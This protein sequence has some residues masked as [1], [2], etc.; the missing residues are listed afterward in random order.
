MRLKM[1]DLPSRDLQMPVL[2]QSVLRHH[3]ETSRAVTTARGS[4]ETG[5]AGRETFAEI[6]RCQAVV[7]SPSRTS[8]S[9]C[10]MDHSLRTVKLVADNGRHRS[11][12]TPLS[13][14]REMGKITG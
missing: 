12:T 11:D 9:P 1:H 8:A 7:Q 14:I 3:R 13:Q 4:S 6:T 5:A 10:V 2:Q